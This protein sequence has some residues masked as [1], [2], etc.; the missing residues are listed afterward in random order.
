ML[1]VSFSIV[2]RVISFH[3]ILI[4][5]IIR[6]EILPFV[7]LVNSVNIA[8]PW[9]RSISHLKCLYLH[10]SATT[11]KPQTGEANHRWYCYNVMCWWE[12]LSPGISVDATLIANNQPKTTAD[13]VRTSKTVPPSA[14]QSIPQQYE[15]CSGMA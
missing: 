6:P 7:I 4:L 15:N 8:W 9:Q 1:F 13:H 14:G 5:H 2:V 10:R 12:T 11:F 3:R